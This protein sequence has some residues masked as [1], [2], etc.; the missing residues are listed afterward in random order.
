MMLFYNMFCSAV[1][2]KECKPDPI[3]TLFRETK[4]ALCVH[5]NAVE[6][7]MGKPL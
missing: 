6:K 2:Q 1:K 5:R 4:T 7:L 3:F